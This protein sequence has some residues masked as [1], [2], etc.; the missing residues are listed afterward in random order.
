MHD[1]LRRGAPA[2]AGLALVAVLVSCD[3]KSHSHIQGGGGPAPTGAGLDPVTTDLESPT[4]LTAPASDPTRLFVLE[5]R[6]TI[7]V[8]RS[9][10]LLPTPFLDLSGLVSTGG[11]QGLLG[12]AFDPTYPTN[13]RFYV[14]YTDASGRSRIVRY[15]VSAN[16]ERAD[17]ASGQ[18]IFL[19]EPHGT[20]KH[21]GG[22][23]AFGPDG[24]LYASFGDGNNSG[25][26]PLNSAQNLGDI[27]GSVIRIDV[28]GSSTGYSVPAD[29]PFHGTGQKP[30][31]WCYGL[32]NPWRFTF[33]RQ[34]ADLYIADVGNTSIEEVDVV[35]AIG[36]G[37]VGGAGAN[38]GWRVLEGSHCTGL[39]DCNQPGLIP[40]T[41]EYRHN[42]ACCVIGG[43]VYRGAAIP[44]LRGTYFY[45]DFCDGSVQSFV[46]SGGQ[47]T[48][49]RSWPELEPGGN[50][51]SFGED[52]RGEL[53]VLNRPL[54]GAGG[55]VYRIVPR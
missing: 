36:Y 20:D 43:Y 45:A 23:I 47:A 41:I 13:G 2:L 49:S 28:S 14:S 21:N 54:G 6:G 34:T 46:Y 40:P 37:R 50:I 9:D 51:M 38:F 24:K 31:I 8:I 52:A 42:D 1:S 44:F 35:P 33:D 5:K 32:R 4:F 25:A 48:G 18:S 27:L 39:G 26:D 55:G 11:E 22:M 29:N 30:E 12:M 3:S 17:A 19:G 15:R 16:P 53:Y 7:R 10:S